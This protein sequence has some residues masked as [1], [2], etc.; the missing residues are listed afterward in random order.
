MTR[1]DEVEIKSRSEILLMREAGLVVARTLEKLRLA[2]SP[3]MSTKDLDEIA[4]SSIRGEG[5]VPSFLNYGGHMG[6]PGFQGSICASVNDEVVHGIPGSRVLRDGDLLSIDCG[7]ILDGWHGDSAITVPVGEVDPEALELS[8]VC[9][10]S[11]WAGLAAA[12]LGGRLTDI[13]HA[14]EREVCRHNGPR[15]PYGIVDNYG[16][17]GIGTAMHQAPHLLNYGRPG[18]GQRLVK[19]LALAVEPMVTLGTPDTRVLEDEWTVVTADGR[20]AAHWE[21]TVAIT[22]EGPWVLTAFDG[23][24]AKLAELG[25]KAGQPVAQPAAG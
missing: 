19:G 5:A 12:Q 17:H 23:G 9:E 7:A 3:G 10:A 1:R 6:Q 13:S 15:G 4:E 21:H 2:A 22:E 14:V 8:R 18:R 20:W 11:L 25:V 16:G 24:V